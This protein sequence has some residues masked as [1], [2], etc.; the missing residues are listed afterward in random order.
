MNTEC[1]DLG[2]DPKQHICQFVQCLFKGYN[3]FN[4]KGM[5]QSKC[6]KPSFVIKQNVN[7]LVF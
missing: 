5:N 6:G 3:A 7:K 4:E 2:Q 1:G